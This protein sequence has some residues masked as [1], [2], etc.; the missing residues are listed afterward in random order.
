VK[1]NAHDIRTLSFRK[2]L[3]GVDG[4]EVHAFLE[5]VA[6]QVEQRDAELAALK[7][8]VAELEQQLLGYTDMETGLRDTLTAVQN[9]SHDSLDHARRE[10]ELIIKQAELD[11]GRIT[12]EARERRAALNNELLSLEDQRTSFVIRLKALV[13]G[14]LD[15]LEVLAAVRPE[16]VRPEPVRSGAGSPGTGTSGTGPL[17]NPL[18]LPRWTQSPVGPALEVEPEPAPGAPADDTY[19]RTRS[20]TPGIRITRARI[21]ALHR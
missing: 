6:D 4:E 10:G 18:G 5:T 7:L 19:P 15:L 1:L 16:P 8:K 9:S 2:V 20:P 13:K 3:R 21:T 11:A 12:A 14:Q 17:R